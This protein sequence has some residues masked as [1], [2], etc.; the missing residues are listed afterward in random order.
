MRSYFFPH[1][2][3]LL[4]ALGLHSCGETEGVQAIRTIPEDYFPEAHA[5]CQE[6]V[7]RLYTDIFFPCVIRGGEPTPN[8]AEKCNDAANGVVADYQACLN[9]LISDAKFVDCYWV[10]GKDYLPV[11]GGEQTPLPGERITNQ[12]DLL[13]LCL[14]A[15][16]LENENCRAYVFPGADVSCEVTTGNENYVRKF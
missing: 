12:V 10:Y 7:N 13:K 6:R 9:E 5:S 1:L 16:T 4:L 15:Q 3:G 11:A 2:S 14:R 8:P